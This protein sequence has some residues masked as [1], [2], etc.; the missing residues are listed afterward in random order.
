MKGSQRVIKNVLAGGLGTAAGGV[1]Q[2][3]AVVLIARQISIADFGIYTFMVALTFILQRAADLGTTYILTREVSVAPQRTMEL[4]SATLSLAWIVC[5]AAA[6]LMTGVVLLTRMDRVVLLT[7]LMSLAG[8]TQFH[9]NCYIAIL[10]A[11]EDNE[12]QALGFV[13]HKVFLLVTI[14]VALAL[15]PVLEAVVAAYLLSAVFQWLFYRHAVVAICGRPRLSVD[16]RLWKYL[17]ADSLPLGATNV[18]RLLGEQVDIL[19]LGF[20]A[21][22]RVVGLYGAP[23][24]LTVGLRFIPQAM[25]QAIFPLYS[26]A[27]GPDGSRAE[28][29][30]IYERGLRAMTLVA[31][32]AAMLFICA[33]VTLTRGLLGARYLAS[34]PAM[35]LLGIAV[36]LLFVA[37][38]FPFVL[39]ALNRQRSLFITSAAGLVLRAA[40]VAALTPRLSFLGPCWALIITETALVAMWLG[41]LWKSGFGLDLVQMLWRPGLAS[42]FMAAVI[43]FSN[44]QS[45]PG[46]IVPTLLGTAAYLLLIARLGAISDSEL[47]MGWEG[48]HFL[49]PMVE[50]WSRQLRSGS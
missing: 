5:A 3:A 11:R 1:L 33:P 2:M 21:D 28:F 32:P 19:M 20:L 15:R 8:L 26:R 18:V 41:E 14:W 44:P 27:A 46:L 24:K 29:H 39:T 7:A 38:P 22:P 17:L 49:R 35:R 12:I 43:H 25:M 45:L 50:R 13:L 40:L 36:W 42:L 30:Q 16:T 23:Y 10:V 48:M 47:A 6:V 31:F 37:S 34:A 9:C 4:L